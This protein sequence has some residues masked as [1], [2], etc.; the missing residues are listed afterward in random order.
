MDK[1]EAKEVPTNSDLK[2]EDEAMEEAEDEEEIVDE[3][4]LMRLGICE[5]YEEAFGML[6][7]YPWQYCVYLKKSH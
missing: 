6:N 2:E 5:E 3:N 1:V 4:T 7:H